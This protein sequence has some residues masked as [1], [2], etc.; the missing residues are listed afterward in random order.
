VAPGEPI[1]DVGGQGGRSGSNTTNPIVALISSR[2]DEWLAASNVQVQ[3]GDGTKLKFDDGEFSVVFPA[4]RSST[5]EGAS[6]RFAAEISGVGRRY[7][8]KHRTATLIGRTTSFTFPVLCRA[9]SR[10]R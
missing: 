4:R 5:S 6:G 8:V 9:V 7:F 2:H 3:V 10:R 1:L